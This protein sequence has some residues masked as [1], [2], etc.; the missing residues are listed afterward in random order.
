ML[1]LRSLRARSI[2]AAT[3]LLAVSA[4]AA[5]GCTS[6]SPS[7][8]AST[9][10]A[11]ADAG[12]SP[13]SV[14]GSGPIAATMND[15]SILFPLPANAADPD[16]LLLPSAVGDQ[17]VLVPSALYASAGPITGTTL[18]DDAGDEVFAAYADLRLIALRID[19]CF[20]SLAPDPHGEGCTAQ[21]RLVF[22]EVGWDTV[23]AVPVVFDSALHVFYE[24]TRGQFLAMAQALV[25]LRVANSDGADPRGPLATHPIMVRQGLGGPMST[26]VEQLVLQYAG[27]KNLVRLAELSFLG[28]G[29]QGELWNMSA[30]DVGRGATVATPRAVPTLNT[31]DGGPSSSIFVQGVGGLVNPPPMDGGHSSLSVFYADPKTSGDSFIPLYFEPMSLSMSAAETAFEALVRVENPKDNSANTVD[32]GSCHLATPIEKF[33]TLPFFGLDDT[34]SPLAFQPDGTSVTQ[35]DIVATFSTNDAQLDL[36]AFSYFGTSPAIS[37]RTV[38]ETASVVEYLNDLAQ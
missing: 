4:L 36:H 38:D 25:A 2:F 34:T 3:S 31:E 11:I 28:P 6:A 9:D 5:V 27:E 20:A 23:N 19:P 18:A 32:C 29:F 30:F 37:Q 33:N 35:A 14:D 10:A 7:A 1:A 15:V 24:L 26:G 8:G 13:P 12:S 21:I 22:Q 16:K 17:G